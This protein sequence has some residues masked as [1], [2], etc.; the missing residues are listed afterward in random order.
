MKKPNWWPK[1]P[2]PL[3]AATAELVQAEHAKLRAQTQAEWFASDV[4]FNTQRI[5]RLRNYIQGETK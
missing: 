2:T 3:E 4:L 1:T 5:Q